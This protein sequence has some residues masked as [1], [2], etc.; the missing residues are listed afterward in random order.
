MKVK[1]KCWRLEVISIRD[2]TVSGTDPST[3][4]VSNL[5]IN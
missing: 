2:K 1:N 4:P 5:L 3:G